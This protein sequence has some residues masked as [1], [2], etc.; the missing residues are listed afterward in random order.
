[1]DK[2]MKDLK[3]SKKYKKYEKMSNLGNGLVLF[4]FFSFIGIIITMSVN[5][6]ILPISVITA[7]P[8]ISFA[9]MIIGSF[10]AD[11]GEKK[12]KKIDE[13]NS[14]KNTEACTQ[15]ERDDIEPMAQ[16]TSAAVPIPTGSKDLTGADQGWIDPH[17]QGQ[18]LTQ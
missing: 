10:I 16:L 1:M 12:I 18:S 4:G 14:P 6:L 17:S 8:M 5:P 2:N 7:G 3:N 15:T 11:I 9:I 13:K